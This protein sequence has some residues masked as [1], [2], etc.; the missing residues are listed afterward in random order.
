MIRIGKIAAT[1][2]LNGAVILTHITGDNTWLKKGDAIMV[3]MQKGSYIP[4]FVSQ[5]KATGYDEYHVSLEEI[6]TQ[7]A[8]KR[9]VGRAVYV[10]EKMLSAFAASSPL[11]WIGFTIVD[12]HYGNIGPLEDVMQTGA[13]WIGKL[14]YKETEVLIPLVDA[15]LSAID[16]KKKIVH[17]TLPEGLLEVYE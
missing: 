8:A 14:T 11:L 3:E 12:K 10:D 1:H 17:T 16:L 6:N 2:A 5:C 7:D 15:T 13:Q 4:Y 9:L